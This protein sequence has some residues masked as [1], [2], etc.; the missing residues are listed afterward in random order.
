MIVL[1]S[2]LPM[3]SQITCIAALIVIAA[4]DLAAWVVI[5]RRCRGLRN[6]LE[7]ACKY[8]RA[9]AALGLPSRPEVC[10]VG[11]F[12]DSHSSRTLTALSTAARY[13]TY[14]AMLIVSYFIVREGLALVAGQAVAPALL[15]VVVC[16]AGLLAV[17]AA[18]D[19]IRRLVELAR[20]SRARA[21]ALSAAKELETELLRETEPARMAARVLGTEPR[22]Y[23]V[24]AGTI[25]KMAF[26]EG[27]RFS[28]LFAMLLPSEHAPV[29]P[30]FVRGA[31]EGSVE[32]VADGIWVDQAGTLVRRVAEG[33][34]YVVEREVTGEVKRHYFICL[35]PYGGRE[36]RFASEY[37]GPAA[38]A[39]D[40]V[41]RGAIPTLSRRILVLP[42]EGTTGFTAAKALFEE[43]QTAD[44]VTLWVREGLTLDEAIAF[45]L[46]DA[47]EKKRDFVGL[48]ASAI[49]RGQ[50]LVI[51]KN[52]PEDDVRQVRLIDLLLSCA[53]SSV[54]KEWPRVAQGRFVQG[55]L[56]RGA[57]PLIALSKPLSGELPVEA[58][59]AYSDVPEWLRGA[60]TKSYAFAARGR[61]AHVKPALASAEEGRPEVVFAFDLD[62]SELVRSSEVMAEVSSEL[63]RR[64]E[65]IESDIAAELAE[66]I[67]G[68][69]GARRPESPEELVSALLSMRSLI[70]RPSLRDA[71]K[72][73][74]SLRRLLGESVTDADELS[75]IV[76]NAVRRAMKPPFET[77]LIRPAADVFEEVIRRV[78][79]QLFGL[80]DN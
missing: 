26:K 32:P 5:K 49:A 61:L 50:L 19:A 7:Q 52:S 56:D 77:R 57:A 27:S 8:S 78:A 3:S 44:I 73:L 30:G 76:A 31:M 35:S 2:I 48:L 22:S 46:S 68:K 62:W 69:L 45:E 55:L 10:D 12:L 24:L 80:G 15:G 74:A 1:K 14:A 13:A 51:I 67:R 66:T 4:T 39:F 6:S 75:R 41:V 38:V 59:R 71:A 11:D 18:L 43:S 65:E 42:A 9:L 23:A 17:A 28:Q 54:T 16:N 29:L 21:A 37:I 79:E 36:Y 60:V 33:I 72:R 25:S 58:E 63:A 34:Y 53:N 47:E 40:G 70:D 64:V 20:I